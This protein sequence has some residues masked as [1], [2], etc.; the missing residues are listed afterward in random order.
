MRIV[1]EGFDVPER[2]RRGRRGA[3]AP[4]RRARAHRGHEADRRHGAR[5]EGASTR[6]GRSPCPSGRGTLGRVLNVLGEPV[7][8]LGEVNGG[9]ALSHSPRR[10]F[11][12]RSVHAARN[13]RD[14]HQGGGLDGAVPEG[15]KD[16]PLRR[17]GRGQDGADSGADSQRGHEARRRFGVRRRGRAHARRQRPVAG[18]AGIRRGRCRAIRRNRARR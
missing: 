5:H 3:A 16:R 8:N 1:S 12:G 4:G 11:A 13:V 17:R 18:N 2:H 9:E 15:R 6:A 10:A 14:R 7:D